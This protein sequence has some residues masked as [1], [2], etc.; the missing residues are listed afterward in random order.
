MISVREPKDKLHPLIISVP[1]AGTVIPDE[2]K[3]SFVKTDFHFLNF[4]C[5][6]YVDKLFDF[7]PELGV[8]LLTT[9]IGRY[10][11]DLN[12]DAN[13]VDASFVEGAPKKENPKNLGLVSHKTIKG[14]TLIKKPI[15]QKE[16]NDRIEKYYRPFHDKL[17]NLITQT[18]KHFGFCIHIDAHSMPSKGELAHSDAG[19][20]RK[21]IVLGDQFGKSCSPLLTELVEHHFIKAGLSVSRNV[22]YAGGFITQNYGKP[23]QDVHT[24]QIEHN[25]KLYMNENSNEILP[26]R[27]E[28]LQKTLHNL[29]TNVKV[30]QLLPSTP[31]LGKS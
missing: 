27:F 26:K 16:L 2:I 25:R 9:D 23:T 19:Q 17:E 4:D 18:K 29:V 13:E 15:T 31:V 11:I 22:P 14:E 6:W 24:L 3:S 12:R 5:D 30:I 21:D 7:A 20:E 8:T 28:S 1:H 10:V